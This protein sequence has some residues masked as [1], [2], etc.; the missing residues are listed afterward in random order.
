MEGENEEI[1]EKTLDQVH[2]LCLGIFD[3]IVADE[4]QKL[5]SPLTIGHKAV[6][7][8]HATYHLLLTA[9]PMI[10]RPLDLLGLPSILW[11]PGWF[12]LGPENF[13]DVD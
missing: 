2:S 7:D 11:R 3:T 5:K 12:D 10:N 9:T 13:A 4:A 8:L 1:D 6:I